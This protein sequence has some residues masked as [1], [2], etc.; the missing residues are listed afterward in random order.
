MKVLTCAFFL[1][2]ENA[3]QAGSPMMILWSGPGI[4]V[5]SLMIAWG[6]EAAQFFIAQGIALAMLALLQTLP[7]F[8]IEAVLAWKQAVPLLFANLAGA[9]KLLTGLGWPMIYFAA[10]SAYRR[11]HER[12]MGRIAL[13]PEQAV[14][15]LG[16]LAG[17][18]YQLVIWWKGSLNV[19]DGLVLLVIYCGYLWIMRRLP[20]EEAESIDQ[21]GGVPRAIVLAPRLVRVL[22]ILGLFLIG[23][24]AVFLVAEPFLL[25]LFGLATK[26]G[27]SSYIFI[28]WVAPM[29]SE[30]PEGIS[31]FYW[32]RD[33]DRASIAL[34]NLV[35]SNINQWTLLAALLP[36][37]LS[38]SMK[39]L[40][41]IPLDS[42]QSLELI[43]TLAQSL[44]GA[45]FLMN[46]ELAWWEAAGLFVLWLIQFVLSLGQTG[47]IVHIVITGIYFGWCALELARLLRGNR[48]AVA[49]QHFRGLLAGRRK[50]GLLDRN[51]ENR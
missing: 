23:G 43:M 49:L 19:F 2:G 34:M 32:A 36:M 6:A 46:M 5:A 51:G 28:E 45:L 1:L 21:I 15:I 25:G 22:S 16:L 11:Q 41:A 13:E 27:I 30:A 50:S 20:P 39:H 47:I 24:A 18:A 14:Q 48:K 8:A 3:L 9:L 26:L 40:T 42:Q 38:L 4:V 44:L 12:P 37:V 31:A 35:S 17:I 10:A 33:H 29:V 7:E